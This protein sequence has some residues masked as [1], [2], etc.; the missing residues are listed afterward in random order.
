GFSEAA[1]VEVAEIIAQA[2]IAGAD[3]NSA[4]LPELK[5]RVLKLAEAHP[6]YPNLPKIGE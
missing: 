5:E 6:L 4:V 1:F 2:L 3:G